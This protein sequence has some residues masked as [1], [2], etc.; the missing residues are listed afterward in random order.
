MIAPLGLT[1]TV[2]G[3]LAVLVLLLFGGLTAI[4]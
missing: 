3:G 1:Q 2:G 4:A